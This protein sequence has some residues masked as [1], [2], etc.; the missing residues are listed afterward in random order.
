MYTVFLAG[1]IASG[2]STVSRLL[3]ERGAFVI[4]LDEVSRE[5]TTPGSAA[6]HALAQEFGTDI[7]DEQGALRR[8]VLAARAF[9]SA[10]STATLEKTMHPYIRARLGQLLEERRAAG[11]VVVVEIPLL[12]RVEDLLPMANE[13]LCVTCPLAVRRLR[14]VGRGM[15]ASDFDARV[16][17]QA[18]DEYL[19]SHATTVLS[20]DGDERD[21]TQKVEAWW[22]EHTSRDWKDAW[23]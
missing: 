12:D 3:R 4:D 7:L 16:S 9:V 14:A 5:V 19:V 21:L 10:Q 13:V 22:D 1:G 15:E 17:R 2:K 20:N 23:E 8:D 18:T 11:G 6:C